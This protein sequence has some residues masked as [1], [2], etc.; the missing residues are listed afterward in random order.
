MEDRHEIRICGFGG[1][2]VMLAGFIIGQAASIYENK[3][4]TH[5]R[6]YGPEARGSTCRGDVVI[7]D[8]PV[9]Y[10]YITAPSVL[11]AMSQMGYDKYRPKSRDDVLIIID[12]GLVKHREVKRDRLRSIPALRFAEELGRVAVANVVVLGF[13]SAVAGIVS[14]DA[15]KKSVL[16]SVPRGTEDLNI[17]AL[18]KGHDY[19]LEKLAAMQ[20]QKPAHVVDPS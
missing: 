14:F 20:R 3:Y 8:E 12:E 6:D 4:V 19:G 5:I 16:D 2:G 7:S 1:Q 15:M 9:L 11:V 17:R 13:F 10:P 18:E